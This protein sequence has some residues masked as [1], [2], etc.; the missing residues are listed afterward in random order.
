LNYDGNF[1]QSEDLRYKEYVFFHV[2][3]SHHLEL[4]LIF[5]V[6][7]NKDIARNWRSNLCLNLYS[8]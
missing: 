1:L 4:D 5:V 3:C 6:S 2:I 7:L 8:Q